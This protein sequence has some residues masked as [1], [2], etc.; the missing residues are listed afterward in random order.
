MWTSEEGTRTL[1]ALYTGYAHKV[2]CAKTAATSGVARICCD[3][4]QRWKLCRGA[5][6]AGFRAVCSS[7]SMT[8]SFVTNMYNFIHHH[9]M[10][11]YGN[12]Y[13]QKEL[14]NTSKHNTRKILNTIELQLRDQCLT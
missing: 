12:S 3:E 7:C 13:E 4:G 10:V 5:V 6:T 2:K 8:N 14:I 9:N 1:V 11:A